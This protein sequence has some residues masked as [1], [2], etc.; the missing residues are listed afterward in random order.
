MNSKKKRSDWS[1]LLP[2]GTVVFAGEE[3]FREALV[4]IELQNGRAVYDSSTMIESVMSHNPGWTRQDAIEWLDFN[5]FFE[6][7]ND[8][9]IVVEFFGGKHARRT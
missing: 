2:P 1:F 6:A 3:D 4:G 5:A 7:P 9:P 8:G